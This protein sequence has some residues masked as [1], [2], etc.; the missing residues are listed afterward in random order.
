MKRKKNSNLPQ[1]SR[2]DAKQAEPPVPSN[3]EYSVSSSPNAAEDLT[4]D[5]SVA[6]GLRYTSQKTTLFETYPG[7]SPESIKAFEE[8]SPG[9]GERIFA[10][11]ERE[12]AATIEER[13]QTAALQEKIIDREFELRS[14]GQNRALVAFVCLCILIGW[15]AK[16][17]TLGIS[18]IVTGIVGFIVAWSI[19]SGGKKNN[20]FE[21]LKN[22][23][24]NVVQA[25]ENEISKRD[26]A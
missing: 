21:T 5:G 4:I 13:K 10:M 14:R 19:F 9:L 2:P 23:E 11:S 16:L 3:A 25:S 20:L 8:A 22:Q 24:K 26:A 6:F 15:L 17:K 12:Q 18:S 7:P 1:K